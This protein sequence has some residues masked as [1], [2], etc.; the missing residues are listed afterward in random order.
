MLLI[1]KQNKIVKKCVLEVVNIMWV[2]YSPENTS[3]SYNLLLF[4]LMQVK[5]V[6]FLVMF[7]HQPI[8]R[9]MNLNEP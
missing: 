7:K 3:K 6:M 2:S 1:N 5:V 8:K 9:S 4:V